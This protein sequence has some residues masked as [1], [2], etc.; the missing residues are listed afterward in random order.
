MHYAEGYR[1][2]M[3]YHD[4]LGNCWVRRVENVFLPEWDG[5][6]KSIRPVVDSSP[7]QLSRSIWNFDSNYGHEKLDRTLALVVE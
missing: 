4:D 2:V 7:G 5:F 3:L 6:D 1:R